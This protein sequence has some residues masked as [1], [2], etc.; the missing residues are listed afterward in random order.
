[1][2][3]NLNTVSHFAGNCTFGN[4]TLYQGP[5]ASSIFYQIQAIHF[6][7]TTNELLVVEYY[8]GVSVIDISQRKLFNSNKF[9]C[10]PQ[11]FN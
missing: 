4:F 3:L 7:T 8:K 6:G 10:F 1:M 9:I 11:K 5:I 2:D